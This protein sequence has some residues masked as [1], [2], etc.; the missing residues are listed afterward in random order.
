MRL[1]ALLVLPM[2]LSLIA[3]DPG[4]SEETVVVRFVCLRIKEYDVATQN[5]ALAELDS[6]PRDSALRMF[7]GD[8]KHLRN[9]I[10]ECRSRSAAV[11]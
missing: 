4:S 6:L 1:K 5:R 2:M 7:I 3:C 8:Y 10:E 11:K 9:K